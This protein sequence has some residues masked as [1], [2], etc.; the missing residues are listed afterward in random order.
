[1]TTY[2]LGIYQY[3]NPLFLSKQNF[4]PS[5]PTPATFCSLISPPP[6][7]HPATFCCLISP[8]LSP[9]PPRS[10]FVPPPPTPGPY[11]VF[12]H[13]VQFSTFYFCVAVFVRRTN[14]LRYLNVPIEEPYRALYIH[15]FCTCEC[16]NCQSWA[17]ATLFGGKTMVVY[18]AIAKNCV[19][20]P[21]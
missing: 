18:L 11:L 9:L 15:L 14:R 3:H 17:H 8:S 5:S 12:C 19:A 1:M 4:T 10:P 2:C 7:P 13:P 20:T 6:P 16:T 21:F